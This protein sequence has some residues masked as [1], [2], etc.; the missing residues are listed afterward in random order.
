LPTMYYVL[1]S[2]RCDNLFENGKVG[3][4]LITY[5]KNTLKKEQTSVLHSMGKGSV[6]KS[7]QGPGRKLHQ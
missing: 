7:H 2:W 3:W 4:N 6:L 5:K 1:A